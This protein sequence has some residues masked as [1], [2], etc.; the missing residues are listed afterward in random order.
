MGDMADSSPLAHSPTLAAGPPRPSGSDEQLATGTAVGDYVVERFIGAGAMGEVYAGRHP[1]IG[2]RVAI[3][4]LR[5][6]LAASAEAAERFV[7][8]ARAVN[9]IEHEN[10]VDVFAFG[11][12][13]DGRLYLV[14]DLVEGRS[15]RAHLID[16]PLEIEQALDILE[17]IAEA[18]DAAHARGVVH[19]D[20]KPDNIV[21]S[22]AAPPKVFV[23]DFG[24]AKL[25]STA[26]EGAPATLG[27]LTG[28]GTWLGTPSYMAP[29]Q[30]SVDG[31][32]PASDRYALGVIAFELLAGSVPFTASSVPAMME[33]HFR[34]EVP[35]LSARGA[36]GVPPAIDV[37]LRKALAKDPQARYPTAGA[38]IAA[39]RAAGGRHTRGAVAPPAHTRKLALPAIAGASVLAAGIVVAVLVTSSSDR[40][41]RDRAPAPSASVRTPGPGRVTVDVLSIPAG[42]EVRTPSGIAGATP[43][44]VAVRPDEPIELVVRKPGYLPERRSVTAGPSGAVVEVQL[45]EVSRFR[46]VWRLAN[47]ELRKFER[48]GDE[49][50][51]FK[52]TEARGEGTF[53]KQY[54][55]SHAEHGVAFGGD[56]VVI[57]PRAPADPSCHL[58]MRVDYHYDPMHDVL[59]QRRE[60]LRLDPG[61]D[62]CVVLSREV[63]PTRLARVGDGRDAYELAAPVGRI[64]P[65]LE[66]PLQKAPTKTPPTK[67][68]RKPAKPSAEL[69]LDPKADLLEKRQKGGTV[70]TQPPPTYTPSKNAVEQRAP[71]Q[72]QIAPQP[73]APP[74][75]A[76]EQMPQQVQRKK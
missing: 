63:E 2:K 18:L 57:D 42:A 15:L 58:R 75:L 5:H 59:E 69:P 29:E 66:K 21:L 51:V 32:G 46:G 26:T 23:L 6:E 27:T 45:V 41:D 76:S 22:N 64:E 68:P 50:D 7:R 17:T 35:P 20:L 36:V 3:K 65:Q 25:I 34:A 19:R 70:A 61:A 39:L 14:M 49:V 40:F 33:Q 60:K 48:R 13:Q 4:V 72:S 31:A 38:L 43:A 52:L 11:R 10:V 71:V 74:P 24:I 12:C 30:W 62:G 67:T 8:E 28:A 44:R 47:G 37:V 73:S 53:F 1:V 9:Q 55:F 54:R 16:G 56:D